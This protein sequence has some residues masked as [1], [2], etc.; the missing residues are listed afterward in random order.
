VAREK[1]QVF[2][3]ALRFLKGIA[4]DGLGMLYCCRPK[5][6]QIFRQI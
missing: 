6:E 3:Q 4:K 5:A 1:G 2:K